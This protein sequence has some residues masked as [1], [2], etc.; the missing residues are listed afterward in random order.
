MLPEHNM[1]AGR[2]VYENVKI[3]SV[4]LLYVISILGDHLCLLQL[5]LNL[6]IG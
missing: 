4:I 1:L 6:K 3:N 2:T 5:K